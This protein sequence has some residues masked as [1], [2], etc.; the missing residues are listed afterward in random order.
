MFTQYTMNNLKS[1]EHQAAD[2]HHSKM[3]KFMLNQHEFFLC[4]RNTLNLK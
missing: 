1:L 4:E 3:T 2:L